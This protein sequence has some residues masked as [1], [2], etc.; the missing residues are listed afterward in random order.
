MN[1]EGEPTGKV[2]TLSPLCTTVRLNPPTLFSSSA[3]RGS[4]GTLAPRHSSSS[5]GASEPKVA[6]FPLTLTLSPGEREQLT[7]CCEHNSD[8]SFISPRSMVLPLPEGEGGVR[9]KET[10]EPRDAS[11]L[12]VATCCHPQHRSGFHF[13]HSDLFPPSAVAPEDRAI[14]INVPRRTG[15]I[16]I[17]EFR[18]WFLCIVVAVLSGFWLETNLKAQPTIDM[19][20]SQAKAFVLF[21]F[22]KLTTWPEDPGVPVLVL[23]ILGDEPLDRDFTNITNKTIGK[24]RIEIRKFARVEDAKVC[25]VLLVGAS[26]KNDL[27]Q[28]LKSLKDSNILTVGQSEG[29]TRLGGVVRLTLNKTVIFEISKSA[30]KRAKLK[31]APELVQFGNLVE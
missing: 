29:F 17:F 6:L 18:T 19:T 2:G 15:R 27:P 11:A 23:G 24:R 21:N 25:H 10:L 7:A 16:S 22:L 4:A 5:G 8:S 30:V 1:H 14:A 20:E 26:E 3:T 13:S 9:G 31:I 28:I 12:N